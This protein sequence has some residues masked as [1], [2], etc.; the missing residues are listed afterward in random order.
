MKHYF[1]SLMTF[2]LLS[3]CS[4]TGKV[5]SDLAKDLPIE[6]TIDLTSVTNDKVP[7]II[8]PGRFT[9]D[10]VIYRLPKVIPGDYEVSDFGSFIEDF[11]ALDYEGNALSIEKKDNNSWFIP[12]AG[13][14]DKITYLVNDTY[15]IERTGA[16]APFSPSG[17][18]IHPDNYVLNLHGFVG[19]FDELKTN[20]YLLDVIAPA[21]FERSSALQ[22]VRTVL[23]KNESQITT[24]YMAPR[25]FD[26][27]DNPMMYGNLDVEAFQVGDIEIVLSVYSP[28]KVHSALNIKV[29]I[30]KMMEAQKAYLGDINNTSRYDIY[31]YLSDDSDTSP[32][33][34]GALEHHTSTVVVLREKSSDESLAKSLIEIV[35]HEFFHI[36]TPLTIHSEYIH[37]FDY[38]FPEFSKHLWMYEGVT[39]YFAHHF[40]VYEGMISESE[41]YNN[42]VRKILISKRLNDT[43]SFTEMSENIT[44]APY[45]R[46]FYNVYMKGALM[47]M[48]IDILMREGSRG[49]RSML[50]LMKEL[51]KQ[52]GKNKPFNDDSII[53]EIIAMTYP[54]IGDFFRTHVEGSTPIN[55]QEYFDKVGLK[56]VG[57]ELKPV[58]NPTK[59]QL[60]LRNVWLKG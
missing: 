35:S 40:Q 20:S 11:V 31:L 28:N 50:S 19:Y 2:V 60:E 29:A 59:S 39:E 33:G 56:I 8:N 15:D 57:L 48:C 1:I 51:S 46:N 13:T 55:Y 24:S 47:G 41:F 53:E 27:V 14:L 10:G 34:Y 45:A 21:T 22:E 9:E 32:T 38:N 54:S 6:A 3:G 18:N 49:E 43:M 52:Y 23:S 37:H 36:I 5:V 7:V 16:F 44:E 4:T 12:N 58:E 30:F 17:T 42:M 25:Y 26:I